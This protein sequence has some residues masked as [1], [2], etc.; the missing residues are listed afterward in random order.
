M[1]FD[2]HA[3]LNNTG[4]TQECD[5]HAETGK[6]CELERRRLQLKEACQGTANS[7]LLR[8]YPSS[9]FELDAEE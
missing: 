2:Y 5:E 8:N 7:C 6:L 3:T 1:R 9:L 4:G